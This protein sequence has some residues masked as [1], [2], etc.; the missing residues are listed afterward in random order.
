MFE[1]CV[2]ACIDSDINVRVYDGPTGW[3]N[4]RGYES[5]AYE[6]LASATR[7]EEYTDEFVRC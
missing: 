3:E 7:Q 2:L 4:D 1:K 5:R 6:R